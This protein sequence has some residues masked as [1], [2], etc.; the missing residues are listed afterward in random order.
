[1]PYRNQTTTDNGKVLS[2]KHG[3]SSPNLGNCVT[4]EGSRRRSWLKDLALVPCLCLNG[5]RV[6]ADL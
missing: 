1:M 6:E 2:E 5:S 3:D 4:R